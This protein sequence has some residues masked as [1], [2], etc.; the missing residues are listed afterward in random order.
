MKQAAAL[1]AAL[2][3]TTR[4]VQ[5]IAEDQWENATPCAKWNVRQLVTHTAGVM[6]NFSNGASNQPLA[7]DPDDY[8]LGDDPAVAMAELS[9]ANVAAWK[10]RGELDSMITLGDNEFPGQVGIAINMLDA[11]VHGWDIAK[12]TGQ[13][14]A[15][16]PDLCTELLGF[17]KQAVPAA[18]RDGDNFH[19]IVDIADDAAV[20]NQLLAY[21]GRQPEP[22]KA[23]GS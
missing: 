14:A 1:E 4:M 2:A 22:H 6:A 10:A 9:A 3:N 23:G 20:Q 7:G 12:A 19:A 18:P 21:L 5:G 8:D 11:Y 17:A 16:D 13:D 15:L